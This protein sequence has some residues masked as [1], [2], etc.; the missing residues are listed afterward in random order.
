MKALYYKGPG[1]LQ[2]LET[3]APN[4]EAN[5]DVIVKPLAVATC[6]LDWEIVSGRTPFKGA[7]ILGHEFIGEVIGLGSEVNKFQLCDRVSIAFQPS[8]GTCRPCEGGHSSAC[9]K[10]PATSM[11]GVGEIS[12]DWGGAFAEQVRIPFADNMLIGIPGHLPPWWFC[13]S[14]DNILDAYRCVANLIN[15]DKTSEV[16]IFGNYDSIPL[17]IIPLALSLGAGKVTFVTKDK[18]AADNAKRL[19]AEVKLVE[20]WPSRFRLCDVTICAVQSPLALHA[21]IRSTRAGG[22][23]TLTSIFSKDVALPLREMYMRGINFHTGRVNGAHNHKTGIELI[24][25][26]LIKPMEVDT[27]LVKFDELIPALLNRTSAKLIA[28][29]L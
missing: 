8:C 16:L 20:Q 18:S 2:W 28:T 7:F 29:I 3:D 10:V 24:A 15:S 17:Y 4:I 27:K 19:G 25:S 11:F 23:C 22:H 5:T 6:D 9:R 13:S 26:G 21:A 1:K 12:G 14:S